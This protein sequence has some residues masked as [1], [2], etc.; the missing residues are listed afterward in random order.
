MAGESV[1]QMFY[2]VAQQSFHRID[3]NMHLIGNLPVFHILH[4]NEGNDFPGL[5]GHLL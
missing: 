5:P 1:T 2:S 3:G 4:E